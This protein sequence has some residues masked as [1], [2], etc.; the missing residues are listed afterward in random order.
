MPR[1]GSRLDPINE[2]QGG[3]PANPDISAP[4]MA[5][6]PLGSGNPNYKNV[7]S[8]LTNNRPGL[9]GRGKARDQGGGKGQGTDQGGGGQLCG[10][11]IPTHNKNKREAPG[12]YLRAAGAGR[13]RRF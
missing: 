4:G 10:I 3:V 7:T 1:S 2:N 8:N 11:A 13:E 12:Q 6:L 9:G 5:N